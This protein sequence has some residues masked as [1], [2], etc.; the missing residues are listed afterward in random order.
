[1]NIFCGS[2]PWSLEE[3]EL[4]GY[5]EAYG[6]VNSARII[7]DRATGRSKGFGFVEMPNDSEAQQA[8]DGLNGSEMKG[9][10]V[11]IN[12]AEDRKRDNDRRGGFRSGGGGNRGGY[13]Y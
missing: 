4:R 1:M 3:S 5:F 10:A 13:N 11:V 8:I 2:L 6:E 9:R 7:T 12:Q